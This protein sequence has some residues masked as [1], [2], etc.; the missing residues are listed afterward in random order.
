MLK[1]NTLRNPADQIYVQEEA[2]ENEVISIESFTIQKELKN[3]ALKTI[4]LGQMKSNGK[5]F[6]IKKVSDEK[7]E[8][9]H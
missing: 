1:I 5:L 4:L 6:A 3:D 8:L 7:A 2:N 9:I